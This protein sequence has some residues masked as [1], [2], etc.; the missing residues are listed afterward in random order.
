[1]L[2]RRRKQK[3]TTPRK[4]RGANNMNMIQTEDQTVTHET[5]RTKRSDV[6]NSQVFQKEVFQK[7]VPDM[8]T[9]TIKYL[10]HG[11][12]QLK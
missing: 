11:G 5:Q 3:V 10:L 8:D 12:A 2:L 4:G 9:T 1:M 6:C 7:S